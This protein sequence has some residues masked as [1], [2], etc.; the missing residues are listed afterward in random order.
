M[1]H[2]RK[3]EKLFTKLKDYSKVSRVQELMA[4]QPV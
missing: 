4:T 2:L 1:F 3:A